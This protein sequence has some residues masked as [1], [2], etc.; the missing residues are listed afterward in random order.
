MYVIKFAAKLFLR[1]ALSID[2]LI[3]RVKLSKEPKMKE[4]ETDR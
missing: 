4:T 1:T 3:N 2:I